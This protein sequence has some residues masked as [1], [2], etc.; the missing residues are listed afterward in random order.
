MQALPGALSASQGFVDWST[1]AGF[2]RVVGVTDATEPVTA[3]RLRAVLKEAIGDVREKIGHLVLHFAGHGFRS[4]IPNQILLLSGWGRLPSAGIDFPKFLD[5]LRYYQIGRVSLFIDACN[6]DRSPEFKM[7]CGE[8]VLEKRDEEASV[9][10]YD[11]FFAAAPGERAF[12]LPA[13]NGFHAVCIVSTLSLQALS[14]VAPGARETRA[15]RDAVTSDSIA[16]ALRKAV[17]AAAIEYRLV[18]KPVIQ[19]TAEAPDNLYTVLPIGFV[20][21][22]LPPPRTPTVDERALFPRY[23]Q[24]RHETP[25]TRLSF[26]P[27]ARERAPSEATI[28]SA[29]ASEP[30]PSHCAADAGLVIIGGIARAMPRTASP[31]TVRPDPA[32]PAGASFWQIDNLDAAG[33]VLLELGNRAYV[34][35]VALKGFI[36]TISLAPGYIQPGQTVRRARGAA[37]LIYRPIVEGD[38]PLDFLLASRRSEAVMAQ[39]RVGALGAGEALSL[40]AEFRESKHRNP[41][42]GVL[43]A[44]LYDAIGDR[45]GIR[46]VAAFYA[47]AGEPIPFDV[48]LV[49]GL[50]GAPDEVGR[51]LV[52]IPPIPARCPQTEEEERR[53]GYFR[54]FAAIG[55]IRVAGG[56]PWM[57]Q[58]WTQLDR[59]RFPVDPELA[60]LAAHLLSAPFTTL[61]ARGG[62]RLRSLIADGR[63]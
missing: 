22:K 20:A 11:H 51:L 62:K 59:A 57:R 27:E 8:G 37:S 3:E 43:A 24:K 28:Y 55:G 45:D 35:A 7:V 19:R 4:E 47:E 33:S 18:M 21:P 52:D 40:A 6:S 16:P 60:G 15:G 13:V 5:L 23:G 49:A 29:F 25:G 17:E 38:P 63:A 10:F 2:D 53:A 30:R 50:R 36:C 54:A 42:M 46:R 12:M 32:T 61:D 58:G 41:A 44:Y 34:G 14:G 1:A 31:A 26:R 56:F 39:L 9:P 48:A